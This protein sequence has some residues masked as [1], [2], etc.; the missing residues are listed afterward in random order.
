MKVLS[1][2]DIEAALSHG[3]DNPNCTHQHDPTLFLTGKC[4]PGQGVEASV[5]QG[6]GVVEIRC[7]VCHKPIVAIAMASHREVS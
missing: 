1:R 7:F 2:Q 3:C 5:T 6:T 4:H